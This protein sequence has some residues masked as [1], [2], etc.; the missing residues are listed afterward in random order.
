MGVGFLFHALEVV[1]ELV[2]LLDF[3]DF[4]SILVLLFINL[5]NAYS[6][7]V[8]SVL[9]PSSRFVHITQHIIA[10]SSDNDPDFHFM[11]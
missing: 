8:F 2:V 9:F 10:L 3:N 1:H 6:R 5:R 4:L 11:A 7:I